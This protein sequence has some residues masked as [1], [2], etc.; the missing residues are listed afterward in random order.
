MGRAK[1]RAAS[2]AFAS[3]ALAT[4]AVLTVG[5][6]ISANAADNTP[7][8]P[9]LP[10]EC[11]TVTVTITETPGNSPSPT[12]TGDPVVTQTVTVTPTPPKPAGDKKDDD[13]KA[14]DPPKQREDT[15][16][17]HTTQPP[18]P[19]YTDSNPG[20]DTPATTEPEVSLPA[21]T[22]PPESQQAP[23]AEQ[24]PAQEMAFDAPTPEAVQYQIRKATPEFDKPALANKL[25]IV[26]AVL[27]VLALLAWLMLEGRLRRMAHATAA[28]RMG[29]RRA[30]APGGQEMAAYPG[31]A[32]GYAVGFVP[33]QTYPVAYPQQ[34]PYGYPMPYGAPP[35][36][37]GAAPQ[38]YGA[39][40][41]YGAPPQAYGHA[42]YPQQQGGYPQSYD[43]QA[44]AMPQDPAGGTPPTD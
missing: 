34:Q 25:A 5:P 1:I 9:C 7:V 20:S 19:V 35:Q 2:S 32:P 29:G 30:K 37:Y 10:G 43:Q 21:A 27:V 38:A 12:P 24:T 14:D 28:G 13:K 31:M 8:E 44:Q 11:E 22:T 16:P 17:I 39:P 36:P 26:A 23:P 41:P 40:Q 15:A 33:V 3:L 42:P 18:V 6:A 4:L